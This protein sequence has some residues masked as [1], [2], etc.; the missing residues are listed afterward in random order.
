VRD[1]RV[2]ELLR[3]APALLPSE[4]ERGAGGKK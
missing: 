1:S 4:Q 2:R 3:G